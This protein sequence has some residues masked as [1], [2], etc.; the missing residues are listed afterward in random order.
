M[1]CSDTVVVQAAYPPQRQYI[2]DRLR[3]ALQDVEQHVRVYLST[4]NLLYQEGQITLQ[5]SDSGY[6]S[7]HLQ[8]I[9]LADASPSPSLPAG[10]QL[11]FWQVGSTSLNLTLRG[12]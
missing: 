7:E 4:R 3:Q 12:G 2:R 1:P 9:S 11:L 10:T 8:S 5:G 6:L